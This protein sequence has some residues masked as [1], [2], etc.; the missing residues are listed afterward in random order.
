MN[1]KQNIAI[2]FARRWQGQNENKR[3]LPSLG[4]ALEKRKRICPL[5]ARSRQNEN[6]LS[7]D[8]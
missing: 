7:Q 6:R 2:L 5:R 8:K 3:D 1:M 4:K